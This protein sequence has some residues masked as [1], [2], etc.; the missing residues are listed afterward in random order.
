[1][2]KARLNPVSAEAKRLAIEFPKAQTRTLARKLAKS[3]NI[4]IETARNYFRYHRGNA[5]TAKRKK[6]VDKST[7]RPN[8]P[9]GWKP[10]MPPSLAEEWTPFDLGNSH[11]TAILSD[12]HLPFHSTVAVQS[13]VNFFKSMKPDNV[14]INGDLMDYYVLSKYQKDPSKID[15]NAEIESGTQ[16]LAWLRHEF[17]NCR[18][19]YKYGNHDERWDLWVFNNA[20]L[21]EKLP[22]WLDPSSKKVDR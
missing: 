6:I 10:E 9:A 1:M 11:K 20:P 17:P 14:L 22:K 21:L 8:Q 3:H 12:V 19:V 15:F 2:A 18:I 5:G 16:F 4:K 13:A 7:V